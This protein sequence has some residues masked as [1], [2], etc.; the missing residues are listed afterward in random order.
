[1]A[2]EDPGSWY[3]RW[4]A[5]RRAAIRAAAAGIQLSADAVVLDVAAGDG[6][7]SQLVQSLTGGRLVV[8]DRAPHECAAARA[9]GRTAVRSDVLHLPFRD[10]AADL[11]IA[12]EII[13]HFD[14]HG[15]HAL[16]AELARVTKPGG[17]LLLSTP[18]RYSLRSLQGLAAYVRTGWVW[19]AED[20]THVQLQSR[21]SLLRL[22]PPTFAVR[23]SL[24]YY[25]V[26]EVR[27]HRTRFTF[28]HSRRP[29]AATFMHKLLVVAERQG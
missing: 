18:N 13:E 5:G 19:N 7:L 28:V 14:A 2:F 6:Q 20:Q 12:F 21:R 15:A 24:G 27:G 22:F 11:T 1:M 10:A 4:M 3:G 29:L 26:P 17:L 9:G 16:I 23:R 25:L 8:N